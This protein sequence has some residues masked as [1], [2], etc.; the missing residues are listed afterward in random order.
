MGVYYTII[1]GF[2]FGIL[3][4]LGKDCSQTIL[5]S[6]LVFGTYKLCNLR[7]IILLSLKC[8]HLNENNAYIHLT[9]LREGGLDEMVRAK[10]LAHFFI[11]LA[12]GR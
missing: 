2:V 5:N 8:P 6:N 1:S 12:C 3:I 9:E 7:H 11:S 10:W 4:M